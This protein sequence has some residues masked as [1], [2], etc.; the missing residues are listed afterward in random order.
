MVPPEKFLHW[1]TELVK[2]EIEKLSTSPFS[3]KGGILVKSFVFRLFLAFSFQI[4]PRLFSIKNGSVLS[5]S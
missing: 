3:Y 4:H 5:E 1:N 2:R